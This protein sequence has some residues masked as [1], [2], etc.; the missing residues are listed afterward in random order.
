MT[1]PK[2][3]RDGVWL[4]DLVEGA[5]YTT[6]THELTA[7]A[8]VAFARD[9]D[10][11]PFHTDAEA[12]RGTFFDGLV[13]SGWHTAAITMRLVVTSGPPIATGIV[14]GGGDIAWPTATRAGDM[15]RV[16]LTI[17]EIRRSRSRPEQAWVVVE[18]LT[19]NQHGD[20]RQSTTTRLLA[21]QRP[22]TPTSS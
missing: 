10:P 6:D 13:A 20:V 18:H 16:E 17:K 14:G 2:P 7:E 12:A 5:T 4:D 8:I 21:W 15:L 1:A 11:Q 19:L 22:A 3:T 9:F